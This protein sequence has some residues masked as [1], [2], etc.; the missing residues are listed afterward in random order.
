ME[1]AFARPDAY[2]AVPRED[3]PRR[4]SESD[5][6]CLIASEDGQRLRCFVRAV[7]HVPIQDERSEIGWGLWVQVDHPTYWRLASLWED[8]D[9][10]AAPPLSCEVANDIPTYPSTRGLPGVIRLTGPD[11]RPALTLAAD[12]E[13]PFRRRGA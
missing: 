4:I 11:T 13:H 5:N 9:Q 3:R 1:P 8:P 10:V 2:V 12:S 6:A 7:L